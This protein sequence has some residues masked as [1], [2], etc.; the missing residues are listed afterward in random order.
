MSAILTGQ[1]G[2]PIVVL[3]FLYEYSKHS[4]S[5]GISSLYRKTHRIRV[6]LSGLDFIGESGYESDS[7]ERKEFRGYAEG[8][9]TEKV[10]F[11]SM[12]RVTKECHESYSIALLSYYCPSL[13]I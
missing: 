6:I 7:K 12:S 3:V 2:Y 4:S 9:S 10:I 11:D 1:H 5:T 13:L 8:G